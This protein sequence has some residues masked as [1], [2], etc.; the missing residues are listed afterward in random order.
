MC[1]LQHIQMIT[2][3]DHS[4]HSV[5]RFAIFLFLILVS[6]KTYLNKK[7]ETLVL[8]TTVQDSNMKSKDL[9]QI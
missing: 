6:L 7:T 2:D 1:L 5:A 8:C 3:Y 4:H 9:V